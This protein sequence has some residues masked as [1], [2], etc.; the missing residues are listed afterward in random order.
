[1]TVDGQWQYS[2]NRKA[3][4]VQTAE[5]GFEPSHRWV[6]AAESTEGIK[7]QHQWEQTNDRSRQALGEE[8]KESLVSVHIYS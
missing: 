3:G 8:P 2:S 7:R 4:A 1:M 6:I 5:Q